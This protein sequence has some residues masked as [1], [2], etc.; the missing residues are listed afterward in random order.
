MRN[1]ELF[2]TTHDGGSLIE[3]P[4]IHRPTLDTVD[5]LKIGDTE[6]WY[7]MVNGMEKIHSF[8]WRKNSLVIHRWDSLNGWIEGGPE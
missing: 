4:G 3:W 8:I 2:Y 1:L 5:A 6:V 7:P